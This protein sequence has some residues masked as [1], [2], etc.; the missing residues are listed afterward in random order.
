MQ[1]WLIICNIQSVEK[2]ASGSCDHEFLWKI[3]C[4]KPNAT[5]LLTI[6]CKLTYIWSKYWIFPMEWNHRWFSSRTGGD[7]DSIWI[8]WHL[9]RK[10]GRPFPSRRG[11]A[12]SVRGYR[13]WNE[14]EVEGN[15]SNLRCLKTKN[16]D[17]RQCLSPSVS[18]DDSA[19]SCCC[20]SL[21]WKTFQH[22]RPRSWQRGPSE[23]LPAG[24]SW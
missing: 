23:T 22:E 8:P 9:L 21:K 19:R 14:V 20:G 18:C 3:Q 24:V 2:T 5:I 1:S 7:R 16:S 12:R 6:Y 15:R 13:G 10:R 17:I 4:C 11:R